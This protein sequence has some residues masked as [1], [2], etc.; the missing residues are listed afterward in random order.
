MALRG[1]T[2]SVGH[3]HP[4]R[5]R[6]GRGH[7]V[8]DL[9]RQQR[10][11]VLAMRLNDVFIGCKTPEFHSFAF[12]FGFHTGG[13]GHSPL[14]K[15][16]PRVQKPWPSNK[17]LVC[18]D[19]DNGPLMQSLRCPHA[20]SRLLVYLARPVR[21]QV[22]HQQRDTSEGLQ[23]HDSWLALANRPRRKLYHAKRHR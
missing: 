5:H 6:F 18:V 12:S 16:P 22:A 17:L 20:D 23:V 8:F 15:L 2:L 21:P 9:L 13:H 1:C 19:G 14:G 10:L 11:L 3:A 7:K 4:V